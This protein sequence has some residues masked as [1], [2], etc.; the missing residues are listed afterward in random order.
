MQVEIPRQ[1]IGDHFL[2]DGDPLPHEFRGEGGENDASLVEFVV[3]PVGEILQLG[4]VGLEQETLLAVELLEEEAE[5]RP[6]KGVVDRFVA[7]VMQRKLFAQQVAEEPCPVVI[8]IGGVAGGP[9][10][11]RGQQQQEQQRGY[12]PGPAEKS[13]HDHSSGGG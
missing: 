3:D 7:V 11:G 6:G 5:G 4:D 9:T 8:E 13:I 12:R 1:Q 10:L 2:D